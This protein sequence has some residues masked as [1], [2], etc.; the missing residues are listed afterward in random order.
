MYN[1]LAFWRSP[2]K[3]NSSSATKVVNEGNEIIIEWKLRTLNDIAIFTR[4]EECTF[5]IRN[6]N[7]CYRELMTPHKSD[8]DGIHCLSFQLL[9][10]SS[11]R[12]SSC[13]WFNLICIKYNQSLFCFVL[14]KW[15]YHL[16][17]ITASFRRWPATASLTPSSSSESDACSL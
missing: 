13:E 4:R 6:C 15:M 1:F 5:I 14:L 12:S 11:K 3:I 10:Y 17:W 7:T 2:T 9:R 8:F 16:K